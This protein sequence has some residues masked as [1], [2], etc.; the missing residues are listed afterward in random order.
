MV[1]DFDIVP[2]RTSLLHRL[3]SGR[4]TE[5]HQTSGHQ[6]HSLSVSLCPSLC[7]DLQV[8]SLFWT[9]HLL[10]ALPSAHLIPLHP[11]PALAHW[12]PGP[13]FSKLLPVFP[14]TSPAFLLPHLH[15]HGHSCLA[16]LISLSHVPLSPGRG[17][18]LSVR[19]SSHHHRL[20]VCTH[21]PVYTLEIPALHLCLC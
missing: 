11:S 10:I 19:L 1:T 16:A 5:W 13:A 14:A 12:K 6:R 15:A 2:F 20:P 9:S 21:L 17:D 7:Q 3:E 18:E 8:T 4:N